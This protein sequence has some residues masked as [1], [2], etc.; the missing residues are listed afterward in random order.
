MDLTRTGDLYFIGYLLFFFFK[1]HEFARFE[2]TFQSPRLTQ[3]HYSVS[4]K[5]HW[6]YGACGQEVMCS[7]LSLSSVWALIVTN[8]HWLGTS[9]AKWHNTH[10]LC[11]AYFSGLGRG[12][13]KWPHCSPAAA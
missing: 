9:L 2:D 12:I 3:K 11:S 8:Q 1:C 10:T 13:L 6:V 7:F 4:T 5:A